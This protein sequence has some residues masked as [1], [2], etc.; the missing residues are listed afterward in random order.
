MK[1]EEKS[2]SDVLAGV[3]RDNSADHM[4]FREIKVALHERGF[5]LLG[6]VGLAGDRA[7][8]REF[9]TGETHQVVYP[10]LRVFDLFD[11]GFLGRG[12]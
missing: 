4:S 10:G 12:R 8:G 3:V 7:N 11:D 6:K 5:G 1:K 9:G 2:A